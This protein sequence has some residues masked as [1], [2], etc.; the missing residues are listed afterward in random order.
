MRYLNKIVFINSAHI[1]YEEIEMDGN[2][3]FTGTQGTGKTTLLR[4]ILFFYTG[5]KDRLG[6]RNEGQKAFDYFYLPESSSYIIYEVT[7]GGSEPPFCVILFRNGLRAA[8]RFVD[9][10]YS[11]DWFVDEYGVVTSDHLT[12]RKRIQE[13]GYD[14]SNIIEGYEKYRDILYGNRNAGLSKDV[15]KYYL[16]KSS[17]YHNIPHIIQNVFLNERLDADFIKNIILNS[18]AGE[19]EISVNVDFYREK[20]AN[21]VDQKNDLKL[22]STPNKHGIVEIRQL[23]DKI[24]EFYK[25][26]KST[27]IALYERCGM[28]NYALRRVEKDIPALENS[29]KD[30]ELQ[31]QNIKE[32]IE[33]LN[34]CYEEDSRKIRDKIAVLEDKIKQSRKG[35]EEY[36]QMGI[37]EIITRQ[38]RLPAL[39][40]ELDEQKEL[41]HRLETDYRSIADKYD[42]L[43]KSRILDKERYI[44]ERDKEI[45]KIRN[46]Y[47][48]V[49]NQ[50]IKDNADEEVKIRDKYASLERM[51]G[52]EIEAL[53]VEV[54]E[55]E[56]QRTLTL[57]S[58]INEREIA[59][60]LELIDKLKTQATRLKDIQHKS[61]RQRDA[62][63]MACDQECQKVETEAELKEREILAVKDR[64]SELR[65]QEQELSDRAQASFCGWLD[66][67]LPGWENHLGKILDEKEVLYN[68]DLKPRLVDAN[69]DANIVCGVSI[70]IDS[71]KRKVRTPDHIKESIAELDRKLIA[72]SNQIIAERE[73]KEKTIRGIVKARRKEI[74]ALEAE[75]DE[76]AKKIEVARRDIQTQNIELD[77]LRENGKQQQEE[78][79]KRIKEQIKDLKIK[80]DELNS[81]RETIKK[82]LTKDLRNLRKSLEDAK[83]SVKLRLDVQVSEIEN[84]KKEYISQHDSVMRQIENERNAEMMNSGADMKML[85]SIKERI[86]EIK[87]VIAQLN[88][89]RRIID[90]YWHMSKTL[91]EK[92]PVMKSDKKGLESSLEELSRKREVKL[93]DYQRK[94]DDAFRELQVYRENFT[95]AQNAL[96][97]GCL[98][99]ASSAAPTGLRMVDPIKC[100]MEC[101]S[102]VSE[103]Q[104]LLAEKRNCED[105]LKSNVNDFKRRLSLSN[106]FKFPTVFDTTE[107]YIDYAANLEQ[108]ISHDMIRDFQHQAS[109]HYRDI[110]SRCAVDFNTLISKASEIERI[111]R[112]LNHDFERKTFAGVIRSIQMR[113]RQSSMRI[114]TQLQNIT[115]FWNINQYELGEYNLFSTEE[116]IDVNRAAIKYLE[117]LSEALN[118]SPELKKLQL[119]QT[120][121]LEFRIQENDNVTPWVSNIRAVGSEGTDI[122][123]KAIINILLIS[124]FKRKTGNSVDFRVHCMMDEIGRLADENIQG[125][126]QFANERGIY[127]VNS[128]PKPHCP[129]AYRHVYILT[130]EKEAQTKI[131]SLL[132][133]RES[134][135]LCE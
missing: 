99:A 112:D 82:R 25:G 125:I 93:R 70:N 50:L 104:I 123:V 49:C 57:S 58:L 53:Y 95:K 126:L 40:E 32:R 79:N 80:I 131:Y 20:L 5:R 89:D 114:I 132:S 122:L 68:T 124:V 105:K 3:H 84:L 81:D 44:T 63:V 14:V 130:K 41:H 33:R 119:E 35:R 23:A 18:V 43:V 9:G 60:C 76:I 2:I 46:E 21:F 107:D 85:R 117:S 113:I 28:F 118:N 110:L 42:A 45:F 116:N 127:I 4:A 15:L 65:V 78:T 64:L 106:T 39:V 16:L 96:E 48:D 90:V 29:I 38:K 94:H 111:I 97:K 56:E 27:E 47:N 34:N 72:L 69:G 37:D 51:C 24:L 102:L 87:S 6:I 86:E 61:E 128:S 135:M 22:W 88:D 74:F 100:D 31:L 103:I 17:Q 83:K 77:S 12:L 62:L 10:P 8:F 129:L 1:K 108:F 120:F 7:R 73:E 67:N 36:D 26:I 54:N 121:A 134:K 30:K 115:E 133:T 66:S 101:L 92:E 11:R 71:I 75:I 55:L 98:F 52:K 19:S 13:L 109:S 59:K 91:F